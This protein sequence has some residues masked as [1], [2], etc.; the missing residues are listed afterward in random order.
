MRRSGRSRPPASQPGGVARDPLL[1][2]YRAKTSSPPRK[3]A[4]GGV[5]SV[6]GWMS[7]WNQYRAR[8]DRRVVQVQTVGGGTAA[9]GDF[10]DVGGCIQ[11]HA[12]RTSV[13]VIGTEAY[14]PVLGE[15]C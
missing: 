2:T 14:P 4:S 3:A 10:A 8:F 12:Y 9:R 6:M 7:W 5:V 15:L 13:A 11:G 1:R